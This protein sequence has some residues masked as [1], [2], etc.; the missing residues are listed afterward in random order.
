MD[1]LNGVGRKGSWSADF[2]WV[3]SPSEER[4]AEGGF[5]LR[6]LR[7]VR[8]SVGPAGH[9]NHLGGFGVRDS[10][11]LGNGGLVSC[12]AS[13]RTTWQDLKIARSFPA[14]SAYSLRIISRIR[15]YERANR[16][17]RECCPQFDLS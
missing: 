3:T 14:P 8:G 9:V 10:C 11:A 4:S 13:W 2:P 16:W 12:G 7:L 5:R 17:K 15:S 1:I 6:L